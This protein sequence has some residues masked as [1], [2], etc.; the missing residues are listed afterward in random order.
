LANDLN[1][2]LPAS[3]TVRFPRTDSGAPSAT[4]TVYTVTLAGLALADLAGVGG[5][6]GV[7]NLHSTCTATWT[8]GGA[9]TNDAQLSALANQCAT[10]YWRWKAAGKAELK[11]AGV[12]AGWITDG[13]HDLEIIHRTHQWGGELTTR[14]KIAGG[15]QEELFHYGSG[16]AISSVKANLTEAVVGGT[17]LVNSETYNY[18]SVTVVAD[19]S[20]SL[21][22][23]GTSVF[24]G[25]TT[26]SGSITFTGSVTISGAITFEF[27][28]G[29]TL[30][31]DNT[32]LFIIDGPTWN[33]TRN[34]TVTI[35]S[36]FAWTICGT[37]TW[38]SVNLSFPSNLPTDYNPTTRPVIL[39]V[40]TA[41][42]GTFTSLV[43]TLTEPEW[44]YLTTVSNPVVLKHESGGTATNRFHTS[45]G[46][47]LTTT[48]DDMTIFYYDTTLQR[49]RVGPSTAIDLAQLKQSAG[50]PFTGN[51]VILS[52]A[53]TGL[54]EMSTAGTTGQALLSN[55]SSAPTWGNVPPDPVTVAHG[56]TGLTTLTAHDVLVGNGTGTVT[57]I[58][59]S[60][61]GKVLTSNGTG[62]DPTFQ[63]LPAGLP[64]PVTVA[65]GGTGLTSITAHDLIIG[66]GASNV[67]LLAP[68]TSGYVLTSNGASSD[69]SWQAPAGGSGLSWTKYTK[70]HSDF[71]ST[72]VNSNYYALLT[73]LASKG[74][75]LAIAIKHSTSFSG[76]GLMSCTMEVTWDPLTPDVETVFDLANVAGGGGLV[77][78]LD[79][80]AAVSNSAFIYT[81]FPHSG[82]STS[83][84]MMYLTFAGGV[85]I[86]V[87]SRTTGGSGMPGATAG[88]VDVWLLTG[89]LP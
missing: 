39:Q 12:A 87:V 46:A 40:T 78:P 52:G 43:P 20:S 62:A 27:G 85:D 74:Y 31:L 57:L 28:A 5:F 13:A 17:T 81:D 44:H 34:T 21:T 83:G 45:F 22:W 72:D 63:S 6:N 55:G 61:S 64:D 3:V 9:P 71:S 76:G 29:S 51:R 54:V 48:T 73:T 18:Y 16:G 59:P 14:L 24:A 80:F 67:T 47:D 50:S 79:V 53:T 60:T 75:I 82:I 49:W 32:S 36:G 56:G 65:H 37:V 4:P 23:N 42:S 8:G 19:L 35:N 30:K 41:A 1:A 69:P 86:R 15:E 7:K 10:D 66:N 68:G 70:S 89:T 88:S 38:C 2:L 11:F 25:A 33:I 26:F 77:S 58:S 84:T